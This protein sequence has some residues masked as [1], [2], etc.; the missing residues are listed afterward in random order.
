MMQVDHLV[1]GGGAVG[2]A[3]GSR[4][5]RRPGTSTLVVEK[6]KQFGMETSSRNSEV[7]HAGIY[8]PKDS[9]KTKLCIRGKSLLYE[10]CDKHQVPYTRVGKWVVAQDEP[11]TQYLHALAMHCADLGVPTELI[12]SAELRSEPSVRAHAALASPTTGIIDAHAYMGRLHADVLSNGSDF[13]PL[14]EVTAIARGLDHYRVL[15]RTHDPDAPVMGVQAKV[16][17]CGP[18]RIAGMAGG[19]GWRQKYRLHFAKGRYYTYSGSQIR[20]SRLIYPVPDKHITS[21][22]THLTVDMGG[23]IRFG[24]DLEWIESNT[25]YDMR[26]GASLDQVRQAVAEYLP[27]IRTEDLSLGY[28][29]IRPKLQPPGGRFHDF[30]V[31]EETGAGMPGFVNLVGIESPGLTSSLA[32]A[33]MV[34]RLVY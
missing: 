9:L 7:I 15:V 33:E 4:L 12:G 32:I 17:A 16:P 10:Y 31:S 27:G 1:I 25:D 14:T 5:S 13:V 11:Q 28:T 2:L 20:V 30:V 29:G 6:N 23:G 8:Y 34:E 22:G 19:D 3:V 26:G 18:I 21:L 24:P